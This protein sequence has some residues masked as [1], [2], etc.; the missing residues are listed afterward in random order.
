MDR[1]EADER[2]LH[3]EESAQN[4]ENTVSDVDP[5]VDFADDEQ[6]D[7]GGRSRKG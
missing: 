7:L 4:V 3:G 6:E 5:G 2:D 1:L